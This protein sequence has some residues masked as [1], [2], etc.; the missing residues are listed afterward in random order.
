M[1]SGFKICWNFFDIF[2]SFKDKN[3]YKVFFCFFNSAHLLYDILPT[4]L[5]LQYRTGIYIYCTVGPK[6][7]S[8]MFNV[9]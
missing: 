2:Y 5:L 6:L 7:F 9:S 4:I 8:K 1:I 3:V